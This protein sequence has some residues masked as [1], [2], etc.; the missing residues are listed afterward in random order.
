MFNKNKYILYLFGALT[1]LITGVAAVNVR[2][3]TCHIQNSTTITE[4]TLTALM[5]FYE[6]LTA[7]LNSIKCYQTL[8]EIG[9]RGFERG[10]LQYIIF[11][12]GLTYCFVVTGLTIGSLVLLNVAEHDSSFKRLL[13]CLTLPISGLLTARFILHLRAHDEKLRMSF[14]D[15]DDMSQCFASCQWNLNDASASFP[16][17]INPSLTTDYDTN[18]TVSSSSSPD[19]AQSNTSKG[20]G[21]QST[22]MVQSQQEKWLLEN[23]EAHLSRCCNP[24]W[25]GPPTPPA[26]ASVRFMER[27][28]A[29]VSVRPPASVV[30]GI[31]AAGAVPVSQSQSQDQVVSNPNSGLE[32][33]EGRCGSSDD[34]LNAPNRWS[35]G[36]GI[37][38]DFG[39]DPTIRFRHFATRDEEEG[40][41]VN[42]QP[43]F[44]SA[45]MQRKTT[46]DSF[47][48]SEESLVAS[49][50]HHDKPC[51][52]ASSTSGS[53]EEGSSTICAASSS[54]SSS[55]CVC[56]IP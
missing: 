21:K 42:L 39:E 36:W 55:R 24:E 47:A 48:S 18:T 8:R 26:I 3:V 10:T 20:K 43:N 28:R 17:T 41:H 19:H 34:V 54:S 6:L 1:L 11:E 14:Q 30:N 49:D 51:S 5:V 23:E 16:S 37:S 12:Q 7:T 53:S 35:W 33:E 50:S 38:S 44:P 25:D 40:V 22:Q 45:R 32:A 46:V 13:N 27:L 56:S 2:S 29:Q 15:S 31:G 9:P 52:C 4:N